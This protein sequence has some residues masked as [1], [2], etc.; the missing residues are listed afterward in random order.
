MAYR[1]VHYLHL[2]QQ[3][4]LLS[5]TLALSHSRGYVGSSRNNLLLCHLRQILCSSLPLYDDK[6]GCKNTASVCWNQHN[7]CI[8]SASGNS[9]TLCKVL[10]TTRAKYASYCDNK[11]TDYS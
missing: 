10:A 1:A 9:M 8:L 3:P 6:P 2:L 11:C 4:A 7:E 5:T